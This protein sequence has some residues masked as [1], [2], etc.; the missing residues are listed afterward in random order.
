MKLSIIIPVFNEYL[1]IREVIRKVQAV[2]LEKEIIVVDDGSTDGT[3]RLLQK[4]G[5]QIRLITQDINRGKGAA[6]RRGIEAATGDIIVHQDADLEYYPDEYPIL[7]EK[8]LSNKADA[9]IG[10]RFLGAHRVF[11]FVHYLGNMLLNL[12]TNIFFNTNLTDVMSGAKAFRAEVIKELPLC[13]NGFGIEVEIV[14][15]LFKRRHRVYEIPVSYDGRNVS[16][17]KKTS[18]KTFFESLYWILKTRF[19]HRENIGMRTLQKIQ[20]M[21]RYNRWTYERIAPFLGQRVLEIGSGI[22]NESRFLVGRELLVLSDVFDPYVEILKR[23]F[24]GNEEIHIVKHDINDGAVQKFHPFALDTVVSMNV[25]EH[26]QDDEKALRN[27]HQLIPP[28]ARLILLVPAHPKLF[29]TLDEQLGHFRRYSQE[30][31]S[32]KLT[33]NGFTVEKIFFH[34]RLGVIGWFFNGRVLRKKLMSSFQTK[35]FDLL[36]PLLK[37]EQALSLPFGLSVIA[38]CRKKS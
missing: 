13:A 14:G 6:L 18:W 15:E 4:Y 11:Y 34:N 21:Y 1:T 31:L 24:G 28:N 16:D 23:R 29:G 10:T 17:G 9:V 8:I 5:N 35:I 37:W 2:P 19:F 30:D 7:L 3:S 12:L 26:I 20:E 25:L 36:V 33:R 22:G 38:V 27:I 32:A